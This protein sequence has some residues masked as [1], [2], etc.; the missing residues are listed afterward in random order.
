MQ[1]LLVTRAWSQSYS[2]FLFFFFFSFKVPWK[3]IKILTLLLLG[4][5]SYRNSGA[6]VYPMWPA[7]G[8][9]DF[10]WMNEMMPGFVCTW[11]YFH[12]LMQFC[13][14]VL[15]EVPVSSP[16]FTSLRTM[17][18]RSLQYWF[19]LVEMK[20]FPGDSVVKNLPANVGDD[21]SIPG[22]ERSP[23]ERN[24]NPLQYS[25]LG[26]PMDRGLW[27]ATVHGFAKKS[28]ITERL[29]QQAETKFS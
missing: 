25:C 19:L 6:S 15:P 10:C 7:L 16:L 26:N 9:F 11:I 5:L 29:K 18:T 12:V 22:S 2:C 13:G 3:S 28:D 4:K 17:L 20:G 14:I 1:G 24:A 27:R 8:K 23:G 21:S